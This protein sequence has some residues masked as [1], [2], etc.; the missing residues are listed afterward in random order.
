M[1]SWVAIT[2]CL[3]MGIQELDLLKQLESNPIYLFPLC[4][5]C[6]HTC[7]KTFPLLWCYIRIDPSDG[8][9]S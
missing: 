5:L 9:W 2:Q 7:V 6:K 1:F 4:P 8:P 3:T